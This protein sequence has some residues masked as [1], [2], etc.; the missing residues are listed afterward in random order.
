MAAK[1]AQVAGTN[2]VAAGCGIIALVA[3]GIVPLEAKIYFAL[4]LVVHRTVD[5]VGI[6]ALLLEEV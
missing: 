6:I 1:T 4:P 5:V 2:L 3:D